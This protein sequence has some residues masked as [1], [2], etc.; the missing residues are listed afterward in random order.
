MRSRP[1][2]RHD[3][4]VLPNEI[5]EDV[6]AALAGELLLLQVS[7]RQSSAK[8]ALLLHPDFF[9]FAP[10]GTRWDRAGAIAALATQQAPPGQTA[11]AEVSGLTGTRLADDV[12]LVTYA[13]HSRGRD[14][15]RS[16]IWRKTRDG[17]RLYFHQGTESGAR[18]SPASLG[19][20]ILS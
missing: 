12:I 18:Q 15:D 5:D 19:I 8:V 16:S 20:I 6:Q 14:F 7:V 2:R 13:S 3:G 9:E 11:V 4:N 17:W 10:S 1:V